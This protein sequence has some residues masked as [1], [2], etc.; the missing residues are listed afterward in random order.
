ML[1]QMPQAAAPAPAPSQHPT[2]LIDLGVLQE[3]V[4]RLSRVSIR[5]SPQPLLSHVRIRFADGV[6]IL[7]GTDTEM[8]LRLELS[9]ETSGA[10]DLVLTMRALAGFAKTARGPVTFTCFEDAD[11]RRLRLSDGEIRIT[12]ATPVLPEDFPAPFAGMD[13]GWEDSASDFT[14]SGDQLTR[15]LGLGRHCISKEETRYYLNGTFLTSHP[16]TGMLRAVSTD[17]HRMAIIDGEETVSF[18]EGPRQDGNAHEGGRPDGIILPVR[19][20]DLLLTIARD[21]G[22]LPLRFLADARHLVLQA[23]GLRLTARNIDGTYPNYLAVLPAPSDRA[24]AHFSNAGLSRLRALV[25]ASTDGRPNALVLDP[26]ANIATLKTGAKHELMVPLQGHADAALK[27]VPLGFSLPYLAAQARVT[28]S[29]TLK[30]G[31]P[32]LPARLVSEIPDASWVL[33]PMRA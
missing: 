13:A 15:L 16:D 3:A 11:D 12:L 27:G 20:V 18:T 29:F 26:A 32:H 5:W 31:G 1:H 24:V 4:R 25:A 6:M 14:L 8:S 30:V 17:G 9:A 28:P 23:P 19:V 10:G 7:D 22:N 21:T 2:A 33:M